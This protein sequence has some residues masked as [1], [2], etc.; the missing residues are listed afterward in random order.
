VAEYGATPVAPGSGVKLEALKS[1]AKPFRKELSVPYS[2]F[3]SHRKG[4]RDTFCGLPE[5]F[6]LETVREYNI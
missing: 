4:R 2:N 1:H 6:A 5:G 3:L